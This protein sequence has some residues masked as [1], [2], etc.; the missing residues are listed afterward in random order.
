MAARVSAGANAL[1][2]LASVSRRAGSGFGFEELM[3]E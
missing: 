3:A 1:I 2:F